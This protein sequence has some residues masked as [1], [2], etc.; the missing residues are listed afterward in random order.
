MDGLLRRVFRHSR[1]GGGRV[2][3]GTTCLLSCSGGSYAAGHAPDPSLTDTM[4]LHALSGPPAFMPASVAN[5]IG[6]VNFIVWTIGIALAWH[7]VRQGRANLRGASLLAGCYCLALSVG[8]LFS[9]HH[10]PQ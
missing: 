3:R 9:A 2:S 6:V 10:V 5:T 8:W 1:A 4:Q 7:N